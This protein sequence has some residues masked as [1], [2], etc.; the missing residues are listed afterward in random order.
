MISDFCD[1]KNHDLLIRKKLDKGFLDVESQ[2]EQEGVKENISIRQGGDEEEMWK[3]EIRDSDNSTTS[4]HKENSAHI[5][6]LLDDNMGRDL[7][8]KLSSHQLLE[9]DL[10]NIRIKSKIVR[11]RKFLKEKEN[12]F[13]KVPLRRKFGRSMKVPRKNC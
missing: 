6:S 11:P 9:K 10:N 5:S 13:F 8:G 3:W 4:D 7:S 12:K 1:G 2:K